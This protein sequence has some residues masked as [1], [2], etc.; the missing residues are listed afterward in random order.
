[1]VHS[2]PGNPL[3]S[4]ANAGL[5]PG[6]RACSRFPGGALGVAQMTKGDSEWLKL[7]KPRP[8]GRGALRSLCALPAERPFLCPCSSPTWTLKATPWAWSR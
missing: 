8:C 2:V 1:M 3:E 4:P 6:A 5:G 7:W